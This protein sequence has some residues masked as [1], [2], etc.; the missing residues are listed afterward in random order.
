MKHNYKNL[1]LGCFFG[2]AFSCC[3][4]Y[5]PAISF[6]VFFPFVWLMWQKR[7]E[8]FIFIFSFYLALNW[9]EMPDAL[10]FFSGNIPKYEI[11]VLWFVHA[12]F[13]SLPWIFIYSKNRNTVNM[14]SRTL[15]ITIL[16]LI[17]PLGYF[18][19]LQPIT[20]A[21]ILYPHFGFVGLIFTV[22]LMCLFVSTLA[23]RRIWN[24]A[25]I[26]LCILLALIVNLYYR[27]P[28]PPPNWIAIN[29]NLGP[30]PKSFFALPKRQL[31]L[32]DLAEQALSEK[33][34]VIIFPENIA[35][36]WLGGTASQWQ[37]IA[38]QALNQKATIV[39]GAQEDLSEQKEKN[40]LLLLGF[41][42]GR[43]Y[44]A[45][46][47]MPWGLWHP[48]TTGSYLADWLLTGKFPLQNEM[49]AYLICYEQMIPWPL[50]SSFMTHPKPT[51]VI[52]AANQWFSTLSGYQKQ[53]NVMLANA[54][55][56]GVPS[57]TAVNFGV[58]T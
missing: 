14:I 32:I 54:R 22:I 56:F 5:S 34:K 33:E 8:S 19:W 27:P 4:Y 36:D 43:Y 25:L 2:I 39:L 1:L 42:G 21:G 23:I 45:R 35:L 30:A 44:A 9:E 53:H 15:S 52:S 17:P 10:A 38:L 26:M 57:L 24:I 16:I 18:I 58:K 46:Q 40:L 28:S 31:T 13:M 41:D 47:P 48:W 37:P 55:L 51:I 50:L 29:T 49:V 20:C 3:F 11:V 12:L 7:F 6:L